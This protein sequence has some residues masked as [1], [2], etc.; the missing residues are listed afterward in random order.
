MNYIHAYLILFWLDITRHPTVSLCV[1]AAGG[2]IG[3][4]IAYIG[5]TS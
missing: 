4:G 2:L 3:A 5:L 1:L